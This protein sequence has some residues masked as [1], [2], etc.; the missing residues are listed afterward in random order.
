MK[1]ANLNN[2]IRKSKE[3]LD[4]IDIID[5]NQEM[6]QFMNYQRF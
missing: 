5:G 4:K 6:K 2:K 3:N 1:I